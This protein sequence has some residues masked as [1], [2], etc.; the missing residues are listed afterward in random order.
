MLDTTTIIIIILVAVIGIYVVANHKRLHKMLYGESTKNV[1]SCQCQMPQYQ[2]NYT[3]TPTLGLYYTNWCGHSKNFLPTWPQLSEAATQ[4]DINVQF[5]KVDCDKE[6]NKC[7]EHKVSGY[8][9]IILHKASGDVPYEGNR[10]VN[11]I[12]SFIKN[13]SQ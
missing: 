13:N 6:P 2:E 1:Q 10:S 8:P 9:T 11:A 12:I 5:V 3:T 7:A 4:N